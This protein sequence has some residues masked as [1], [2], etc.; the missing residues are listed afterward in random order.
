MKN[1]ILV[2]YYKNLSDKVGVVAPIGK[3]YQAIKDGKWSEQIELHRSGKI[4]GKDPFKGTIPCFT[5][6]GV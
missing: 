6:G 1:S 3:I 4:D 5:V 2:S